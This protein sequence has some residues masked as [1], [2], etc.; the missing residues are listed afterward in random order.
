MGRIMLLMLLGL[1]TPAWADQHDPRLPALFERLKAAP[2]VGEARAVE[3]QIWEAWS[4]TDDEDAQML[5]QTG[6]AAMSIRAYQTALDQLN[7]LVERH[8]DL[9]EGWNKRATLLYATGDY[10]GSVRDIQKT[11]SLEPRHFGALSGLG[12]IFMATGQPAAAIRAFEAALAIDPY[13]PGA[14]EN[15][16]VLEET[17]GGSEL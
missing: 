1:A 9:A 10:D 2:D 6:V 7:A 16:E 8:P 4:A 14:R 15:I 11:L 17:L 12:L 3:D 5:L 13:L